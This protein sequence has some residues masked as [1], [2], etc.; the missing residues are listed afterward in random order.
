M[1]KEEFLTA[2]RGYLAGMPQA[3]LERTLQYYREMI[4]DRIEDGMSEEQ[5]VA[6]VGD[7]AELAALILNKPVKRTALRTA[8]ASQPPK[9]PK[10]RKP[11][12]AGKKLGLLV[13]AVFFIIAGVLLILSS[14][15]T[16][17]RSGMEREYTFV[18]NKISNI[19][20]QSG[21][22]EVRVLPAADGVCRVQCTESANQK[23]QVLLEEDTLHVERRSKW[24]LFPITLQED[25]I[26]VWMPEREYESLWIKSS[27]GGVS[28]PEGLCF[29]TALIDSSSGS[30][31]FTADVTGELNIHA[32]SG[33]VNVSGTSPKK[34]LFVH[35]S[36]GGVSLSDMEPGEISLDLSSGSL[37]LEH[38]RCDSL[39]AGNSSG[40]V[41]LKDVIAKGEIRLNCVS[42]SVKLDDC[43][44][45]QLY[46]KCTS[47][48][49]SGH[50]LTDKT[51]KLSSVSGS[52]SAPSASAP[53]TDSAAVGVCEVH[54]TSGSIHFD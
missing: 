44:A 27:S 2:L 12:S 52:I 42:G 3:D 9:A 28:I 51:Y 16:S 13:C 26:R 8:R 47:G 30:V 34:L 50:L 40:S 18:N 17:R 15:N 4:D 43:D 46:I 53:P 48:S 54:T 24:T 31:N 32:S 49:V 7:P 20:I 11:M 33:G 39:A 5:A 19:E 25:Y 23:Y 21:S 37:K 14:L 1:T 22:A 38:V 41:K 10:E 35:A 6:D 36:S 29:H 45:A